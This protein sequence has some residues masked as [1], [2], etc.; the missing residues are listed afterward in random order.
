[1]WRNGNQ[2]KS[3]FV[4][5][6]AIEPELKDSSPHVP[7]QVPKRLTSIKVEILIARMGIMNPTLL[8]ALVTLVPVSSFESWDASPEQPP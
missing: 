2:F 1:M 4:L 3:F 6:E 8:K 7:Q 5:N